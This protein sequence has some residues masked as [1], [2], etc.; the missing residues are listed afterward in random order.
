[1]IVKGFLQFR[2]DAFLLF[3]SFQSN[4]SDSVPFAWWFVRFQPVPV[5]RPTSGCVRFHHTESG[6]QCH[7]VHSVSTADLQSGRHG[8][9][10]HRPAAG[11]NSCSHCS[12]CEFICW[13]NSFTLLQNHGTVLIL[14][15]TVSWCCSLKI[16]RLYL[17]AWE[18][19]PHLRDFALA[20]FMK[21]FKLVWVRLRMAYSCPFREGLQGRLLS[22]LVNLSCVWIRFLCPDTSTI[23]ILY[24]VMSFFLLLFL[25]WVQAS[26]SLG[27][28]SG[29]GGGGLLSVLFTPLM[30]IWKF[31]MSFL[32]PSPAI[33]RDSNASAASSSA[34]FAAGGDRA[35]PRCCVCV[36]VSVFC[37]WVGGWVWLCV[38]MSVG[39]WAWVCVYAH[40]CV[41]LGMRVFVYMYTCVWCVCVCAYMFVFVW[42][43]VCVCVYMCMGSVCVHLCVCVCMCGCLCSVCVCVCPFHQS[44]FISHSTAIILKCLPNR[45]PCM[46]LHNCIAVI[47]TSASFQT[48]QPSGL[49][50]KA[51]W[52]AWETPTMTT[53]KI[54]P[55][56]TETPRNS[57]D[58]QWRLNW[59]LMWLLRMRMRAMKWL[60]VGE[61]AS[62]AEGR[63]SCSCEA[64]EHLYKYSRA[65][66]TGFGGLPRE[67]KCAW[68][69]RGQDTVSFTVTHEKK[70][71][72]LAWAVSLTL[73]A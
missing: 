64:C 33:T 58:A 72:R 21:Q 36:C 55:R 65:Y 7:T 62:A 52:D 18:S 54:Q 20:L 2:S 26:G 28:S 60:R 19:A 24:S 73:V 17:Q 22:V 66:T 10:L 57:C 47:P 53:T 29:G 71:I 46:L 37:V 4:S 43:C 59:W 9:Q 49:V 68:C 31:I 15:G 12:T 11:S 30:V 45:S 48:A 44:F 3:P 69:Q 16:V 39:V 13:V 8:H 5:V 14:H 1:M 32:F 61:T 40:K 42:V 6:R 41:G 67:N 70:R 63:S 38:C 25:C 35:R 34:T 50:K 27:H 23:K 51:M 56:G